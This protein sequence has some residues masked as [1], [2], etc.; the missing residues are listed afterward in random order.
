MRLFIAVD[1]PDP[2]VEC[3]AG[4]QQQYLASDPH[5]RLTPKEQMHVTLVFLSQ[6]EKEDADAA[7]AALDVLAGT[8]SF[9]VTATALA[10][11]PRGRR[12]R[13]VAAEL[14]DPAEALK[15]AHERLLDELAR[16]GLDRR[17]KRDFYHHVTLARSRGRTRIRPEKI[18]P[19]PCQF[20]AVRASLY[21]SI[22]NK[23]GAVHTVLKSVQL[24]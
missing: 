1:I 13:V 23:G 10:G 2:A 14:E 9:D 12:P 15:S 18:A 8:G 3:L 20:T 24:D 11:L 7:A 21:N 16:K 5:L 19:E 6:A 4:W 17:E 22:L